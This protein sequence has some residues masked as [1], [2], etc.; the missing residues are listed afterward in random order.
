MPHFPA[1][2]LSPLLPRLACGPEGMHRSLVQRFVEVSTL[3]LLP[4]TPHTSEHIW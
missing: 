3:L 2:C 4:F 1:R